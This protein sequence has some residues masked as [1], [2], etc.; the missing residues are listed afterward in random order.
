M[1]EKIKINPIQPIRPNATNSSLDLDKVR[2]YWE[3]SQPR[4]KTTPI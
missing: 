4:F 1:V 2:N 3:I